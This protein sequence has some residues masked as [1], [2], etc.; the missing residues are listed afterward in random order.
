MT[1]REHIDRRRVIVCAGAGGVGTT[2]VA[3]RSVLPAFDDLTRTFSVGSVP[4]L[5]HSVT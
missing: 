2:T 3:T 5:A 4:P 1:L